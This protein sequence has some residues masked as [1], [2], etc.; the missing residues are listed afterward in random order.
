MVRYETLLLAR[1]E[2][3][4]DEIRNLEEG[5]ESIVQKSQGSM[6]A[7]DRWGKYRL[8]YPV[9]RSSYGVYVLARYELPKVGTYQVLQLINQFIKVK[10]DTFVMR[11]TNAKLH[12][13]A[14]LAYNK[15][16]SLETAR[17]GRSDSFFKEGKMESLLSSVDASTHHDSSEGSS[18]RHSASYHAADDHDLA[19]A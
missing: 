16:E 8:S 13:T 18:R 14:S 5:I 10:C 12:P 7:F 9:N 4:E 1:T 3:T 11:H 17:P 15:P 6:I 2:V 19:D